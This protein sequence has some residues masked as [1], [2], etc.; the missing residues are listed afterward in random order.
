MLNLS[1]LSAQLGWRG[2]RRGLP[3]TVR[4][5]SDGAAVFDGERVMAWTQRRAPRAISC[6][7]SHGAHMPLG[8]LRPAAAG[9]LARAHGV[10]RV[11]HQVA[12]SRR[13]SS[14]GRPPPAPSCAQLRS[15]VL[16]R[17]GPSLEAVRTSYR[18]RRSERLKRC[19][20]GIL[21]FLD[22]SCAKDVRAGAAPSCPQVIGLKRWKKREIRE[23]S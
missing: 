1:S 20:E 9:C 4:P 2:A 5:S 23:E 7:R 18:Y 12:P 10:A 6:R 8:R 14:R 13:R 15:C 17:A 22:L 3:P 11:S 16:D 19:I 21:L